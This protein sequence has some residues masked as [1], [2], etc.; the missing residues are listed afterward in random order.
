MYSLVVPYHWLKSA[1][2]QDCGCDPLLLLVAQ[3]VLLYQIV[4]LAGLHVQKGLQARLHDWTQP[5]AMFGNQAWPLA[6]PQC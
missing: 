2:G 5:Q 4:P 6:E 1:V 3:T